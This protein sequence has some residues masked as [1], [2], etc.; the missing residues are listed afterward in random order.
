VK[1]EVRDTWLGT[2]IDT[3]IRDVHY[4]FRTLRR[5]PGFTMTA[6]LSPQTWHPGQHRVFSIR[7]RPQVRPVSDPQDWWSSHETRL[8]PRPT[9]CSSNSGIRASHESTCLRTTPGV[10]RDS[11]T[12]RSPERGLYTGVLALD[13]RLGQRSRTMIRYRIRE[14]GA[15]RSQ[16]LGGFGWSILRLAPAVGTSIL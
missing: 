3:T 6:L 14:D 12:E 9:P 4:A 16:F 15:D 11:G 5:S 10:Q 2:G 7:T 13:R 8:S 1:E